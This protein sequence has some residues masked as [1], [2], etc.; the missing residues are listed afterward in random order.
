VACECRVL[1][2]DLDGEVEKIERQRME[3]FGMGT[4]AEAMFMPLIENDVTTGTVNALAATNRF[5]NVRRL[6]STCSN[7]SPS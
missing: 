5:R 6:A 4:P 3:V 1:D 7:P 2:F